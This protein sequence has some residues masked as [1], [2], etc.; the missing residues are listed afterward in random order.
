[1][2]QVY[3]LD[4]ITPVVDASAFVHPT[5]VLI[6]DVI[7][8]PNCYIGPGASLRGD[9]G[10]IR[11]DEGSNLQDNCVVHT[12]PNAETIVERG[13]HI[14]HGAILHGCFIRQQAM[15]GMHSVVMDDVEI[16]ESA[17]VAA[18]TFV[19]A[20]MLVPARTL[21]AGNPGRLVRQLSD[22]EI[23]WKNEGTAIYQ[24]LT[25][26]CQAGLSETEPLTE[27]EPGRQRMRVP[28]FEPLVR[29]KRTAQLN[30][31][32]LRIT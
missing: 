27:V 12:F 29:S 17:I 31:D 25:L 10:R 15:V 3:S 23:A 18:L 20:G 19:K 11:F 5:A 16:G 6:G 2:P 13:G 30:K 24:A 9:F 28:Q 8:G 1:M 22:D 4:G 32:D 7:V 14:G 26:R 21:V